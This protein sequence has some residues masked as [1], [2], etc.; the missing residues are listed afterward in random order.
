MREVTVIVSLFGGGVSIMV[1]RAAD[2]A[3]AWSY[4]DDFII[5]RDGQGHQTYYAW[6]GVVSVLT[7][8]M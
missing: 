2:R 4:S 8:P 3:S 6:N 7:N 1:S 5:Y